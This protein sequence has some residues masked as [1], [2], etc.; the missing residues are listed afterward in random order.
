M[1]LTE[2]P[3]EA[4]VVLDGGMVERVSAVHDTSVGQRHLEA[5]ERQQVGVLKP[6]P[7]RSALDPSL[8]RAVPA[9]LRVTE[10]FDPLTIGRTI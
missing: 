2:L 4:G 3:G 7:R 10:H 9:I 8:Q 5:P 6:G 1:T